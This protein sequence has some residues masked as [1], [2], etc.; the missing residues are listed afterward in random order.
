MKLKSL[1][2]LPAALLLS[3]CESA[4]EGTIN[5]SRELTVKETIKG[6]RD[7]PSGPSSRPGRW[8]RETEKSF[9]LQPGNW[10]MTVAQEGDSKIVFQVKDFQK[11]MHRIV[12]KTPRGSGLP[13]SGSFDLPGSVTGQ[14]FDVQ[15]VLSTQNTQSELM[16]DNH[17]PCSYSRSEVVCGP[18][19]RGGHSCWTVLRTV[20]GRRQVEYYNQIE[21]QTLD[22][23]IFAAGSSAGTFTADRSESSKVY[24]YEGV[25][26]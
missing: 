16:R 20:S 17:E 15:G 21:T 1:L 25:C 18:T 10:E 4:L 14:P 22:G 7:Y 24:T 19:G 12:L 11:K 9:T 23:E 13:D 5:L 2:L 8:Q 3:A 6:N 26:Y